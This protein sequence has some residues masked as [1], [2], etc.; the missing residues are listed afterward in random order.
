[1]SNAQVW[2]ICRKTDC[3]S[4]N[5]IYSLKCNMC[6]EKETYIGKTKGGNAKGFNI[7]INQQIFDCKTEVLTCKFRC[8]VYDCGVKNNCLE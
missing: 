2:E 7:R 5:V 6:N 3:H 8:H 4:V 1:M